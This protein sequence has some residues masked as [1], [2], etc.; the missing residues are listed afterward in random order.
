M[1]G[2]GGRP[3]RMRDLEE[4]LK[5]AK[6][7]LR[8]GDKSQRKNVFLSFAYEDVDSVNLLRAQAKNEKLPLEF[9]DWS[10]SEPIDSERASYIKEKI[11][12]RIKRSSVTVVF[13]SNATVESRWVAW[14][15][16]RSLEL[17]KNVIGVYPKESDPGVRP[18][19]IEK[20]KIKCVAWPDLAETIDS[21][22]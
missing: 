14:E 13:L 17:G 3:G 1:G 12:E 9:S 6:E 15:I 22:D 19:A 4:L 18:A 2:G 10:V 11:S 8:S 16:E 20:H 7:E 21:L 5:R